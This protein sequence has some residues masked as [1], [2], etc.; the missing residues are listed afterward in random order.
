MVL[1]LRAL[2]QSNFEFSTICLQETWLDEN[3]DLSLLQLEN[4]TCIS[5][6]KQCSAHGGLFIYLHK[7]FDYTLKHIP[8]NSDIWEGLFI[9]ISYNNNDKFITLAN[10]YKPPKQN[11]NNTNIETFINEFAPFIQQLGNSRSNTIIAGDFNIYLLKIN[12][13]PVFCDF[14]D[15]LISNSYEPKITLPTRFSN[16]NCTLMDNIFYKGSAYKSVEGSGVLINHILGHLPCL[17]Y[18]KM[19]NSTTCNHIYLYK[20]KINEHSIKQMYV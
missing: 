2:K 1:F 12:V 13:R 14:F 20:C 15:T 19:K 17:T 3:A 16:N 9:D 6:S 11:N 18:L 5:K 4:Y 10:I 7:Q 8:N